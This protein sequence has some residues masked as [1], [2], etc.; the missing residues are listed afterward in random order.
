MVAPKTPSFALDEASVRDGIDDD[1]LLNEMEEEFAAM[2]RPSSVESKRELVEVVVQM[3]LA[4]RAMMGAEQPAFEQRH[5]AVHARQQLGG[6]LVMA[7]QVRNAMV[8]STFD[9]LVPVPA[10]GVDL[11]AGLDGIVDE[12]LQGLRGAVGDSAHPDSS[13][14]VPHHFGGHHN[15]GV[16]SRAAAP[17]AA[18]AA[19]QR[20]VDL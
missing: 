19:D 13:D 18:P 10:I 3:H 16:L 7:A 17:A 15:Q 1:R 4:D 12:G 11:A 5:D 6:E 2:S 8:I 9:L 20:L 14:A